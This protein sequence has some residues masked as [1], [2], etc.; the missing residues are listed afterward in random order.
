[1][2]GALYIKITK[3]YSPKYGIEKSIIALKKNNLLIS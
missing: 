3:G 1:M 2:G